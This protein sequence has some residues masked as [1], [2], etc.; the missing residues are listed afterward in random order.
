MIRSFR[1]SDEADVA[2][3]CLLT[4]DVGGDATGL[5]ADDALWAD[6]FALP[7]IAADPELAF[8]AE[9]DADGRVAGYVLGT[10]DTAAF[11]DWWEEF[12]SPALTERY[13][14]PSAEE[15]GRDALIRRLAFDPR[16]ML[17]PELA[18]YPAHLHID[19]EPALQGR[20]LGRALIQRF[21][22]ALRE[23]GVPGVHLGMDPANVGARA[24]YARLGFV[25]LASSTPHETRLGL[26]LA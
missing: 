10:A 20:G 13:V 15:P 7:Y 16:R 6:V 12:W 19:L 5:L 22:D 11:V 3:V 4:A 17:I 23:R 8:V 26:R 21:T 14:R 24:F 9:E 18:A 2:H 1:P 25:E